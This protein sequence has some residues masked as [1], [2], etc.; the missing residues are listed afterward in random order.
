MVNNSLPGD[1]A[2]REDIN[3]VEEWISVYHFIFPLSFKVVVPH[4]AFY[5]KI[6]NNKTFGCNIPYI[7]LF[8]LKRSFYSFQQA[9]V[10][11]NGSID[12][13][14]F[15]TAT[16]HRHK[17]EKDEHLYKAFSYFDKDNSG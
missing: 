17:L 7:V 15:I 10:D 8:M 16:M 9:D 13:V 11:G 1:V 14:E 12:Y 6:T 2:I 5:L 3:S 4:P